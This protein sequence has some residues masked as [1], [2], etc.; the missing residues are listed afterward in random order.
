MSQLHNHYR[1]LLGLDDSWDVVEVDLSLEEKRVEI[2]LTHR[3]GRTVNCPECGASCSIADHAAER[4]WRHL[5]TMQFETR[6]R[7]RLPRANCSKCGIKTCVA[8]W[9]EPHSRF[10]LLFESFAI[11]VLQ[12]CHTI[13][14]AAQL[15]KLSWR[16]V[17]NIML[18][19]VARGL[20]SRDLS[21]VEYVGMDEKSIGR[22]HDYI[23]V[24]TDLSHHRVLEV[25][26]GR[27]EAAADSLWKTPGFT[28]Q[29]V[30]GVALD[31]WNAYSKA[32]TTHAPQAEQVHD[33]FHISK[34]L[35]EAVNHV[36]KEEHARLLK[37]DDR[38][39]TGSKQLWLFNPENLNE[40]QS[41]KFDSLKKE[42]LKTARAWSIK[43][44]FR[45]FWDYTYAANAKK[46]FSRWYRWANRSQLK[47]IRKVA[48]MLKDR[49]PQ[50]L[51]YFRHRITNATS[52]GF[53]SKIQQLKAAARGIQNFNN[54]RTRILFFCGKLTLQP[55]CTH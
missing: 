4:R 14:G 53:N 30:K 43:E 7:A 33:R 51:S 40:K 13:K 42:A 22:G 9:A 48:E 16:S 3:N 35:N 20:L 18:R 37:H 8:P 55:N 32:A 38:T 44:Q 36:R 11:K 50:L 46:F 24:L 26:E 45:W 6:L 25:S 1:L 23:S 19:A 31:M 54:L 41:L 29:N 21:E 28:A 17:Q 27:D 5:D 47:P 49:L 39:L 10:T 34:H 2:E 52:E 15:L 12:A